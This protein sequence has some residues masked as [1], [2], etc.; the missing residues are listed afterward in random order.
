L[1]QVVLFSIQ[2]V[3]QTVLYAKHEDRFLLY[4]AVAGALLN[5]VM[6]LFL[7]PNL[8]TYGAVLS[9]ILSMSIM[10]GLRLYLLEKSKNKQVG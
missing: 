9:T 10:L 4:S 5:I 6:N 7:V 8:G 3:V 2:I 1:V